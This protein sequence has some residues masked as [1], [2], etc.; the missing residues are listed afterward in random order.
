MK[1][2]LSILAAM[3]AASASLTVSASESFPPPLQQKV[4]KYKQKL[5]EWA[6]NPVIVD[7]V[8]EAN[9]RGAA[10]GMSNSKW[11]EVDEKSAAAQVYSTSKAGVLVTRWEEDKS[12]NKL[13]VRDEKGNL[14]AASTKPLLYNNAVRPVYINAMKGQAW[15]A[16]A[17]A[18]DPTTQVK[19]VQ[20]SAPVM[21]GGKVIGVIHAGISAE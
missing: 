18:P 2:R 15:A 21:D 3:L 9:A 19:S 7:A 14:V 10:S 16:G 11:L 17:V 13:V 4:D 6:A 5:V 20:A 8:K 12:I 1:I